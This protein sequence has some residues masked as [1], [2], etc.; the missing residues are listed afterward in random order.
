MLF[1]KNRV[2]WLKLP[3]ILIFTAAFF[4][5]E[6]GVEGKLEDSFLRNKVFPGLRRVS[7]LFSDMKFKLRGYREPRNKIIVVEVD[8]PSLEVIG[9]WPWHRDKIALLIDKVFESGA[10]VVGMDVVFSEPDRRVSDELAQVLIAQNMGQ[11]ALQFETDLNLRETIQKHADH[12]VLGW[13]TEAYCQ[14]L[15]SSKEDCPIMNPDVLATHPPNYAKFGYTHF[16]APIGFNMESTPLFSILTF[17]PNLEIYNDVAKHG[18]YFNAIPDPDGVVRRTPFLLVADAKPYPSLPLEMARIGLDEELKVSIEQQRVKEI[19]FAKSGRKFPV[20]PV[21]VAEINFRGPGRTFT[22]VSALDIMSDEDI[23]PDNNL[24]K[25]EVGRSIA[26]GKSKKELLKDAYVLIGISALGVFDMRAFP[27]DSNVAGVEGHASILDNILA[28]DFMLHGS[29]W[30]GSIWVFLTMTIGA[31]LFAYFAQKLESVP[32]M[33]MVLVVFV[34]C[35]I[36]DLKFLF[37]NNI[38]WD[39]SFLCLEL[40]SIFVFTVVAKYIMEERNK[41]FIRGAFAKYVA[42]AVVDSIMKDPTKLSVGGEKKELTI[43]FS[44]I[45]SF[46]TFSE[47]M[48][49]KAL[50]SFLN[51][52]LGVMTEIVFANQGTLD[53]Y[54][55]DA[56]MAFWGAPL[57][58]PQHAANACK[59][60]REMM[61]ALAKHKERFLTQYGVDVNI[62]IGLNSGVVSVGNM[63][64]NNNFSY[65]V[66]GDHVNLASRLEGLT[67]AYGASIVTSRFTYDIM[68]ANGGQHPAHR[69]LDNVK[70]KGK[71]KAVELIQVLDREMSAEGMKMFEEG[72]QLYEKQQWDLAIEKFRAASALLS[73]S[74]TEK[75][76]PCDIYIERCEDFK[77]SPPGEAW[78]GSWEMTSK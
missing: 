11:L 72:R 31:L 26:A 19:S 16:D 24:I 75:D 38:N 35:G 15:Y 70:V 73:P 62:G 59:A 27:F 76:E 7:T 33:L 14:P 44:D 46:T 54:I 10:K 2:L 53:K 37:E 42:P 4:I 49:A 40:G 36:L 1:M 41:K 77:K 60:A 52:Y 58:Q 43:L 67:K 8:S 17:I 39:T 28:N 50:S 23:I 30:T 21:G 71:K 18:G 22:Y 74:P 65:T 29:G 56:I 68:V 69:I 5:S 9:R 34:S 3:F 57:D 64:S 78:D 25:E 48:D 13:T 63:G 6:L 61:E 32:A 47:K 12:L 66:I 45:R 55:G 20:S 51:D